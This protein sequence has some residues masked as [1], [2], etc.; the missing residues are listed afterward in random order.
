MKI[1]HIIDGTYLPRTD[2]M[3]VSLT[4]TTNY[5]ANQGHKI[6]IAAPEYEG[7]KDKKQKHLNFIKLRCQGI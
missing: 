5:L 6:V 3:V 2:G 1:V 4:N 7:Y